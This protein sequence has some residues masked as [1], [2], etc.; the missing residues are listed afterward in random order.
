MINVVYKKTNGML[1]DLQWKEEK[2]M[3]E[4]DFILEGWDHVPDMEEVKL[5][6][7]PEYLTVLAKEQEIIDEMAKIKAVENETLRSKAIINISERSKIL[8]EG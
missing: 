5:L 7:D 2:D 3:D 8:V 6:H 1:H 4:D